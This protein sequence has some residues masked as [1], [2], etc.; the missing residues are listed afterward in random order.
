M[1]DH[2]RVMKLKLNHAILKTFSLWKVLSEFTGKFTIN[3]ELEVVPLG[4]D[5]HGVP[6]AFLNIIGSEGVLDG[7][8]GRFVGLTNHQPVTTEAAMFLATGRMKI[9]R[10]HHVFAD[11]KVP[12]VRMIAL[13]IAFTG[14]VDNGA[15]TYPAITL[16]GKPVAEFQFQI[17]HI[18]VGTLGEITATVIA[19]T[20][21][22]A[23]LYCPSRRGLGRGRL[24]ALKRLAIEDGNEPALIRGL[25][26]NWTEKEKQTDK[27]IFHGVSGN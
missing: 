3:V 10:A 11:T 5:V 20:H 1:D 12:Q 9:P 13:K 14:L 27:D 23:L 16:A 8:N 18:L 7:C 17:S 26:E 24:P 2:A 21:N 4:N 6:V 15:D 25:R 19:I 22:H